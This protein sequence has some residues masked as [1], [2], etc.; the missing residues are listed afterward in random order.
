MMFDDHDFTDD[1]N[2]NPMWY[3][4]V[5]NTDLGVTSARNALASYAI[6]QDWGN[7]PIRYEK[8]DDYKELL[9]KIRS[10]FRTGEP[11]PDADA[12][13]RLDELFGF[14]EAGRF[15]SGHGQVPG[16]Q[17]GHQVALQ[18]AGAE[19]PRRRDRQ[20]HASLVPVAPRS[21]GQHRGKSRSE[22]GHRADGA[23]SRG[24][25]HGRQGSAARD[26]AAPGD[27]SAAARRA[28]CAR[29]L[30]GFRRRGRIRR[31]STRT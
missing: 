20:P 15:G 24:A 6:F 27:R 4:R 19:A 10:C 5:Y 22:C 23:D 8:R 30:Q 12:A 3:D 26:R 25:V 9:A 16:P 17:S 1:W 29:R 31:S 2:L 13:K 7:D 21:P 18:R 11:G 28:G 14:K